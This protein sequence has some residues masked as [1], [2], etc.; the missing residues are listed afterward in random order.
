[1]TDKENGLSIRQSP[2]DITVLLKA[3]SGGD[4]EALAQLSERVYPELLLMARRHM[5]NE[6]HAN[7]LQSTA[8]VHEV[9]LRLLDVA[10]IDW[11]ERAQF[12]AMVATMMRRILVD[13]ARARGAHKRGGGAVVVD[14]DQ[15]AMLSSEPHRSI[16]ALDEALTAFAAVAP[17]QARVV[18]LRYFGGLTEEEIVAA[19]KIAPRTVRRD[20]GLAK[21]WLLR[22]LSHKA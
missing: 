10:R 15:T 22:E 21:A 5:K 3:W 18:E 13:A 17:R 12:F 8:L 11:H 7:T 16:L 14:L 1:L 9:Y 19:L 2:A 6:R 4:Q 20:W